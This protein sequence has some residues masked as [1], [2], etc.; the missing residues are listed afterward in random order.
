MSNRQSKSIFFLRLS[1]IIQAIGYGVLTYFVVY[2]LIAGEDAF[3]TY[4]VNILLI[5]VMLTCDRLARRFAEK[6]ESDIRTMYAEMGVISKAVYQF[7][8]GFIRTSLYMFYI[9]A[10]ILSG[11]NSLKPALMPYD[12][13]NFFS[14][15][16][17]GVIL[18][19]AFDTLIGLLE[20]DKK[21]IIMNL[22]IGQSDE[23]SYNK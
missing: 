4:L 6:R 19:F 11:V 2:R 23:D 15:I 9:V 10:L 17:Y 18:L 5:I 7:S 21:W 20:K 1:S 8:Q 13:G 12:L 3:I 16:E 22:G 14:S